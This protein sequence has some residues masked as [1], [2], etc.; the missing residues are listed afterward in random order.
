MTRE[1][2]S[3]MEI[4]WNM[5]APTLAKY[6]PEDKV[7]SASKELSLKIVDK[8]MLEREVMYYSREI[9]TGSFW[10]DVKE[11]IEKL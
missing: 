7:E 6:L 10:L 11:E 5:V 3:A 2:K 9:P 1:E 8:I 4:M